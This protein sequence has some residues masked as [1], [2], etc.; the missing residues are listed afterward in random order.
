MC[1]HKWVVK[2]DTGKTVYERCPECDMKRFWQRRDGYQ[3]IDRSY[4]ETGKKTK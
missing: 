4:L 2:Y 1:L 3:P